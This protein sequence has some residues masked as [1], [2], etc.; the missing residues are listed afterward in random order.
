MV[1]FS[2]HAL[3]KLVQR[4]IQ[5]ELVE[6]TVQDPDHVMPSYRGRQTA[7]KKYGQKYLKVV[8]I[9]QGVNITVVTQ[10]WDSKLNPAKIYES[11]L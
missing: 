2:G 7:Y 3:E 8:F 4:R 5:K 9:Q 10:H 11:K 1:I 6:S